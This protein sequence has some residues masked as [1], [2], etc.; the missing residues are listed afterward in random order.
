MKKFAILFAA[1]ALLGAVHFALAHEGHEDGNEEKAEAQT[2]KGEIVDLMCYID[3]GAM[4]E[5]HADC[6]TVCIKSGGPVGIVTSDGEAYL[7][8]GQHEPINKQ[9]IPFAGKTI[10]LKG[11]VVE[12]GGMRMIENSEIVK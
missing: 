9:L 1:G 11:K 6:A 5:K 8:I 7:V 4:G 3:H 2:I 10:T 12:R